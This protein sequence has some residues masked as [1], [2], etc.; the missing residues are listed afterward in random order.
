MNHKI[1][2]KIQTIIYLIIILI[3]SGGYI[4]MRCAP[5]QTVEPPP[6]P[7]GWLPSST[8][9]QVIRHKYFSLSY[10]EKHEQAEW[11]AYM[12]TRHQV[13]TNKKIKRPFFSKDPLVKT[14]SADYSSYKGSGYDKG[15][16]CP[17]GDR[18][19]DNDAFYETFYT[20]NISP[21][22]H[23]FNSGIWNAL[24]DKVRSWAVRR[25]TV[26]VIT[27]GVLD[28]RLPSIG[29]RDKVSVPGYFYKIV[30]DPEHT[31][32]ISFLIPNA[33]S[34]YPI[35]KYTVTID[36]IESIT[37]IDFFPAL[38]DSIEVEMEKKKNGRKQWR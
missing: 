10:N 19:F 36:S 3:V 1:K 22:N 17:A 30:F 37:G 9:G 16:L 4:Y 14:G 8:T 34:E 23:D 28:D 27:G 25:D 35:Y 2:H 31:E 33:P 11:V 24:E 6:L 15:H 29:K 32:S 5:M 26:F 12:L 7:A 38:P 18:N 20:S 13:V 21:Q